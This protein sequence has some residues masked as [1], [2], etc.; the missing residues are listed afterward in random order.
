[1]F[2]EVKAGV[3]T[4]EVGEEG[5]RNRVVLGVEEGEEVVH[6]GEVAVAGKFE[7]EGVEGGGGVAKG[8]VGGGGEVE[9]FEG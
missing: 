1:M 3:D 4:K 8:G 9:D 7:D 6:E 2:G 5:G